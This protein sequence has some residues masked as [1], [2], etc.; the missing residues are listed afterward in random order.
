MSPTYYTARDFQAFDSIGYLIKRCGTLMTAFAEAA[1]AAQPVSFTQ[2]IALMQLCRSSP[3]SA[4]ELS[5][6]MGHDM[7][8]L[9]RVIDALEH[10]GLVRRERSRSDRRSVEIALTDA[11]RLQVEK[12]TELVVAMLNRLLEPFS[13]QEFEA[14][15]TLLQR[16]LLRL[17]SHVDELPQSRDT[18]GVARTPARRGK[19]SRGPR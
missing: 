8:A 18:G 10:G 11:G 1:F 13:R 3:M 15:R 12:S 2:W 19:R 4:T 7:G 17:Q 6:C 14:M 5:D 16:L 9:T